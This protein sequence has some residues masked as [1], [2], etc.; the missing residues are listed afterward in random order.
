[1]K[2]GGG[3]HERSLKNHEDGVRTVDVFVITYENC[4]AARRMGGAHA[5]V[6]IRKAR[7]NSQ[8]PTPNSQR[9]RF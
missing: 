3:S 6:I 2:F 5:D 4:N 8:S 7:V 1:M 9:A